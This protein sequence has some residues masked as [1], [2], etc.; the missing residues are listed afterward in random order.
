[1]LSPTTAFASKY[2]LLISL[3]LK[4]TGAFVVI[5]NKETIMRNLSDNRSHNN[6]TAALGERDNQPLKPADGA[7]TFP[8]SSVPPTTCPGKEGENFPKGTLESA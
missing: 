4:R 8:E 5:L 3:W 7:I 1:M 6:T 2:L